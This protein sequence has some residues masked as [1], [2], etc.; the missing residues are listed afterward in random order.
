MFAAT[1]FFFFVTL[2][3]INASTQNAL[4]MD[5]I[6]YT[7]ENGRVDTVRGQLWHYS[8]RHVAL[9]VAH[10]LE[11]WMFLD[12]NHMIL[13]Y[14]KEKKA[15]RFVSKREF[16]MPFF[17]AFLS[18]REGRT[19]LPEMG[20]T[21]KQNLEKGDTLYSLWEP[22]V[23]SRKEIGVARVGLLKG[24]LI[25]SEA[26]DPNGNML[27]ESFFRNYQ[28]KEGVSFP[29]EIEIHTNAGKRHMVEKTLFENLQPNTVLPGYIQ[30]F[31]IP[32]DAQIKEM[33]W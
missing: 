18:A 20:F 12:S 16:A 13:Y 24:R 23:K 26:D 7:S 21:L 30:D 25:V 33:E 5:F 4:R 31:Q 29:M 2:S 3:V 11:Q 22:P 9:I 14:P 19:A 1:F 6:R 32:A 28:T 17:Q 8:S 27:A 10:P 15:F